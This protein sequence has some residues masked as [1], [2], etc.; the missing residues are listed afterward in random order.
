V[1]P[2]KILLAVDGSP[3]STRAAR[4]AG[5]L[6]GELDSE[7]HLVC[8][9][10]M[11]EGY[12]PWDWKVLDTGSLIQL[13]EL[14]E[15][16]AETILE[17]QTQKVREA[18]GEVA[19]THATIGRPKT[20]IVK[21]AEELDAGLVVLGSRGFGSLKRALLGS[22]SNG[23][24]RHTHSSVL[25]VRGSG[26]GDQPPGRILL[27]VDGSGEAAAAAEAAVEISS[28]TGSKLH[29]LS[30][31][32]SPYPGPETWDIGEERLKRVRRNVRTFVYGLSEQPTAEGGHIE[33]MHLAFGK[34]DKEI[35]ALG[36]RIEVDLVVIGSR[37]LS[38]AR[39]A[40]L[41]SVSDSV[42]R[43]AHCSVLVV[44]DAHSRRRSRS[45]GS[46]SLLSE[47]SKPPESQD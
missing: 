13:R 3:E 40:L 18:D 37:G 15:E 2:T 6:S 19:E 42:V 31:L 5:Q 4:V 46:R 47:I 35:V 7:L 41:G 20:E 36:E 1:F 34:P 14:A 8:V 17:E 22:V 24:V 30:V 12:T 43:H 21:L 28:A 25:V 44:R 33:E 23:V 32:R 16:E 39:R 45:R 38:G 9:G 26:E 10:S 29:V 11:L 27:A